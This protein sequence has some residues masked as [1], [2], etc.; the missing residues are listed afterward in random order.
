MPHDYLFENRR[1][2]ADF[3]ILEGKL[4]DELL[5]LDS[6]AVTDI[7]EIKCSNNL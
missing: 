4:E 6:E 2:T 7:N 5:K 3:T 1:T